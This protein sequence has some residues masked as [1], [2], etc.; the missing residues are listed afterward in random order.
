MDNIFYAVIAGCIFSCPSGSYVM[1]DTRNYADTYTGDVYVPCLRIEWR[2]AKLLF[3]TLEP[4][5]KTKFL[6]CTAFF[7]TLQEAI[8]Y[9]RASIIDKLVETRTKLQR[10]T[11]IAANLEEQLCCID[12][13][14]E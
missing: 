4:I 5:Y 3:G 12:A 7:D 1:E 2:L 11:Y 8:E 9:L 10:I 13:Y 6:D 14:K